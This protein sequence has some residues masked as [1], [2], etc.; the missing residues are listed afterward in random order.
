M[1]VGHAI[2]ITSQGPQGG[3]QGLGQTIREAVDEATREAMQEVR[4]AQQAAQEE[5]RDAQQEVR[6]AQ[7]ELRDAQQQLREARTADQ[8]GSAEQAIFGAQ[9]ELREAQAE[10]R[11]AEAQLR[12]TPMVHTTQPPPFPQPRIPG[13]A[14]DIAIGFFVTCAVIIVGWPISRALGRRFERNVP[15]PALQGDVT[16][17]L[18][19]IEQAVDAIA[20]EVERI[21]E[22]QRFLTKVQ[23]RSASTIE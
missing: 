22:S 3:D 18:Q 15:P 19:R 23:E 21:S 4:Q 7:Q 1:I 11:Q 13:E 2:A 12:S 9:Q 20:I 17:Q 16:Q 6:D 10:L 5:L 8:R 14:V